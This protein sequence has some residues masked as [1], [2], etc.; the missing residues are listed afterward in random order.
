MRVLNFGASKEFTDSVPLEILY[1]RYHLTD[2]LIIK[3]IETVLNDIK[4]SL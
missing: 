3:D 1:E 2:D 4:K